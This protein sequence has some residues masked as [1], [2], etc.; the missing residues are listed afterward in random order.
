VA[1]KPATKISTQDVQE[2]LDIALMSLGLTWLD[3]ARLTELSHLILEFGA[4]DCLP[5]RLYLALHEGIAAVQP[6]GNGEGMLHE[7]A[8]S[9]SLY[10]IDGLGAAVSAV[11]RVTKSGSLPLATRSGGS[12]MHDEKADAARMARL[13]ALHIRRGKYAIAS[14]SMSDCSDAELAQLPGAPTSAIAHR[15]QQRA[16]RRHRDTQSNLL[17]HICSDCD[18][19]SGATR[20]AANKEV[21]LREGALMRQEEQF[22]RRCNKEPFLHRVL[23][24]DTHLNASALHSKPA[25]CKR[26]MSGALHKRAFGELRVPIVTQHTRWHLQT[27][28][29]IL[30]ILTSHFLQQWHSR[31][32]A[33]VVL[34]FILFL[35]QL[36]VHHHYCVQPRLETPF[37]C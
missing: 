28:C 3:P 36:S 4:A 8:A 24:S 14:D 9:Q 30:Q 27:L 31:N 22:S 23:A 15:Q 29:R 5:G 2:A 20:A 1:V 37:P 13:R 34:V 26:R 25:A 33:A 6:A 16:L 7:T 11:R 17:K 10:S 12:D 18:G 19:F 21:A 35:V 32:S